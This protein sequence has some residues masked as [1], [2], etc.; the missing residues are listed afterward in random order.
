MSRCTSPGRTR[1]LT[2]IHPVRPFRGRSTLLTPI[3][4][5]EQASRADRTRV[6]ETVVQIE[7]PVTA[8]IDTYDT[9]SETPEGISTMQTIYWEKFEPDICHY[10]LGQ[11]QRWYA[12]QFDISLHTS[13][14]GQWSFERRCASFVM[15]RTRRVLEPHEGQAGRWH[16][17]CPDAP[18]GG[19]PGASPL[20][21]RDERDARGKVIYRVRADAQHATSLSGPT[22]CAR[23]RYRLAGPHP[24][25][26]K[27]P[28]GTWDRP[29][30]LRWNPR[31]SGRGGCQRRTT[32][33]FR[34]DD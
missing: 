32:V 13:T 34:S 16:G 18:K 8:T 9:L 15:T 26:E 30:V 10:R 27:L 17:P 19:R 1:Y 6:P 20:S 3:T 33:T 11:K 22:S 2:E 31:S 14:C 21:L 4:W 7:L 25:G 23:T 24:A 28:A 5:V 12:E 29:A